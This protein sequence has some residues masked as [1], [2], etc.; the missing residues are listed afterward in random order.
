MNFLVNLDV[1]DLERGIEF[2]VQARTPPHRSGPG[3][4]RGL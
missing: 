2:Y 4:R 1:D 3:P